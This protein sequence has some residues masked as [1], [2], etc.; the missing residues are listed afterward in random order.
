M[1]SGGRSANRGAINGRA[2]LWPVAAVV[3]CAA[4]DAASAQEWKLSTNLSQRMLYSDN[5]LL[6]RRNEVDTFGSIT[7]P[8]L[9]LERTSPTS[10]I[11]LNGRFEFE[12]YFD[13]SSFDS[14]DQIIDLDVEK[15]LSE[16]SRLGLDANFT[17]DTTLTSEDDITNRF[18]DDAIRFISWRATPSWT[19]DLTPLD[20]VSLAGSYRQ[21]EYDSSEKTDY[22]YFGPTIGY[23]RRLGELSKFTT[24][25]SARR[26]I[27]DEPGD[28]YTD[29]IGTLFGYAY[30]SSERFSISGAAGVSYSEEHEE[31]VGNDSDVGYRLKFDM[32]YL[33]SEQLT[34]R[35]SLSHDNEPSGDG[36][37]V[38]R[39]RARAALDYQVTEMA[40]LGLDFNYADNVDLLGFEGESTD[41]E[42]DRSRYFAVRPNIGWQFTEDLSLVASYQFRY[43]KFEDENDTATSNSVFLTLQYNFPTVAGEGF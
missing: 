1:R 29:T 6:N 42:D 12:E 4:G 20:Q 41:D 39:N 31:D 2:I 3:A 11:A 37:Q 33:V 18:L 25:L 14:Q 16:R 17:R 40:T 10:H 7:T 15:A 13:H 19:Y 35:V 43:K 38:T 30:T 22:Q 34:A 9:L 28:N 5:L 36:D 8:E 27:P 24:E 26:F 23:N 32:K 21:V